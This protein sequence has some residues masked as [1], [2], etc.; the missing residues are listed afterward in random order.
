MRI[1]FVCPYYM[2]YKGGIETLV[3]AIAERLASWGH[4]VEVLTLTTSAILPDRQEVN[5]VM[6]RRFRQRISGNAYPIGLSLLFYLL[7]HRR[8]YDVVNAHNYHALPLLWCSLASVHPLVL[9]THY[10]G[11]GHSKLANWMHPVYRPLGSWAVRQ[12]QKV[13]C[14]SK[15]EQDLVCAHLRVEKDLIEIVPNGVALGELQA[16]RPLDIRGNS[17]GLRWAFGEV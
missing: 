17:I 15:I 12:G 3:Q 9:S 6:I 13:I 1:G 8:D 4:Q 2:P 11:R 5:R 7:E 16:A 14:A 10:H